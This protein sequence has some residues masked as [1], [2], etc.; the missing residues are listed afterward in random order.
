MNL[1]IVS[2]EM[3]E[4]PTSPSLRGAC[5]L[6][7]GGAGFIGSH[8]CRSLLASGARVRVLDNLSTGRR[9]R[10]PEG[11]EF[12]EGCVAEVGVASAAAAGCDVVFHLAAMV[13][14]PQSVREP[15]ACLRVN[16]LGTQRV[17]EAAA[18][19]GARRV[20]LASTCA[21]YGDRPRLPSA[22]GDPT[23]CCS[24]YAASKLAGEG[25]CQS[26][27]A[28]GGPSAVCLRF[29][30]VYG[31]GQDPRS[32]YAA[33]IS[34]FSSALREGRVPTIYGDGEQTRDFVY[35]GDVVRANMMAAAAGEDLRGEVLNVGTG[36]STSL[37]DLLGVLSGVS[38]SGARASHEAARAGDVR[39]SRADVSRIRAV[40]GFEALTPIRAGLARTYDSM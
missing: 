18:R 23:R 4:P 10:V 5:C 33:V 37:L 30:N 36:V 31:P 6:V 22:E 14:V 1:P 2:A 3:V 39:H 19:A 35:V 32:A 7:T 13:S 40:L 26:A 20:V 24:P 25:L 11:A 15:E 9:D 28:T 27:A 8:L 16:V 29:F 38:G 34:A 12:V 21:V 17:L